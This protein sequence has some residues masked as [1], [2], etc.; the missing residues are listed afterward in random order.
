[1]SHLTRVA[2]IHFYKQEHNPISVFFDF[3]IGVDG[4]QYAHGTGSEIALF[5]QIQ[6][7]PD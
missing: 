5:F 4:H 3:E 6:A 1:M 7:I 2:P